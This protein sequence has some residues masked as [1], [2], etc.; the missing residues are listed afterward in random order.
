MKRVNVREFRTQPMR[1]LA[2]NEALAIEQDGRPIGVYLPMSTTRKE[3][4]A[5]ALARLEQT[6]RQ[7]L[8]ETGL[9]EEA[10]SRLFDVRQPLP[11]QFLAH[12]APNSDTDVPGR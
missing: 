6:V 10:L 3:N 4:A 9:T 11:D 2:G 1:Y 5:L 7:V 12:K 8:S